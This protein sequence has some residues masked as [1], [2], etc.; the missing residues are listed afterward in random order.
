MSQK[1]YK[2]IYHFNDGTSWGP[3]THGISLAP[4]Q[5]SVMIK[6]VDKHENMVL[7]NESTGEERRSGEIKSIELVF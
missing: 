2:L 1:L 3:E 4:D 7:R 6:E 5:I